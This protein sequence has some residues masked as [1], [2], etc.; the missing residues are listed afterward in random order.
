MTN[1]FFASEVERDR[2]LV[3]ARAITSRKSIPDTA[4]LGSGLVGWRRS[5][6]LRIGIRVGWREHFNQ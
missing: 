2:L 3:P 4:E 1:C 6:E 5:E